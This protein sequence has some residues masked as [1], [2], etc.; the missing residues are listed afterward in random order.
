MQKNG[1]PCGLVVASRCSKEK[2]PFGVLLFTWTVKGGFL[3]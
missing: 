2:L 1:E 3:F